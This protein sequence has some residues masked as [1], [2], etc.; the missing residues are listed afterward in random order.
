MFRCPRLIIITLLLAVI[1]ITTAGIILLKKRDCSKLSCLSFETKELY[2]TDTE[3]ENNEKAYRAMFQNDNLQLR[4]EIYSQVTPQQAAEY[5]EY[6]K[7]Q[8]MG[9]YENARSPYPGAI[10]DQIS[11]E[12]KYKPKFRQLQTT[13]LKIDYYIGY[14]NN[15]MQY[16]SCTDEQLKYRSAVAMLYCLAQKKWYLLEFITPIDQPDDRTIQIIQSMSCLNQPSNMGKLF[17]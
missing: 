17:P 1:T 6:K 9:L 8:L 15:R 2:R 11:C 5:N 12:D 14:L 10:S 13:T 3:Y 16:G 4:V 7:M